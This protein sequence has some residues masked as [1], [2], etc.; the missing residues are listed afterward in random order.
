MFWGVPSRSATVLLPAA[1]LKFHNPEG[2]PAASACGAEATTNG[3]AATAAAVAVFQ[4]LRPAGMTIP[5]PPR[6]WTTLV[7]TPATPVLIATIRA[8]G[9]PHLPYST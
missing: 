6:T 8:E 3:T 5:L 9:V 4:P 7:A 1:T 2:P